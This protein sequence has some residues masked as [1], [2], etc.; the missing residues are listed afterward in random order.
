MNWGDLY[1]DIVVIFAEGAIRSTAQEVFAPRS[2]ATSLTGGGAGALPDQL[3]PGTTLTQ[4]SQDVVA[5][6]PP[7]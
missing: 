6:R 7:L 4:R 5:S 3:T 2:G 1:F